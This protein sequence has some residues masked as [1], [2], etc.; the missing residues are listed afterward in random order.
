MPMIREKAAP[1]EESSRMC[2]NDL[3][4]RQLSAAQE[5]LAEV[6]GISIPEA[7]AMIRERSQEKLLW[8]EKFSMEE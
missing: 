1:T 6:F 3:I 7:E 4:D 8:L 5:I 2:G